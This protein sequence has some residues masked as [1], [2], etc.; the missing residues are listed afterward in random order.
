[1]KRSL[2]A[3]L[4]LGVGIGMLYVAIPSGEDLAQ[5][6]ERAETSDAKFVAPAPRVDLDN[7]I[8]L[9]SADTSI[10]FACSKSIAGKTVTV[11]GG[12]DGQL[13][14]HVLGSAAVDPSGTK[15]ARLELRIDVASL[16]SEHEQLTDSLLTKGFFCLADY[17]Q[18]TF[19]STQITKSEEE[20]NPDAAK[21]SATSLYP[22]KIEGN[23]RLNGV[24]K[25]II[26]PADIELSESQL[27]VH[28]QFSLRRADFDVHFIDTAG[29]G[30][31]SDANISDLV[32]VNVVIKTGPKPD[33]KTENTAGARAGEPEG[34]PVTEYSN[35][36]NHYTETVPATQIQFEMIL[37]PGDPDQDVD[38]YYIGKYEVTWDEFMPWV[39]GRDLHEGDSLGKLRAMKLRPSPP[40]GS[41]DRGFGMHRRP[42][43][44]MSQLSAMEYC[45]WLSE[46]T[47]KTYRLPTEQEWELAYVSGGGDAE[48][49]PTSSDAE[50][51]AVYVENSW[52]DDLDD[53]TTKP[54][55]STVSNSLGISDMA[56]NVCEWV[57]GSGKDRIA[58]GGH[59]ESDLDQ[60][61]VGRHIEGPYWNRD[62][63]N[64]PKSIWWFINARWV[65]F[66]VVAEAR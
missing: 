3:L 28:S 26:I 13:G 8:E 61:G 16:W 22:Y 25:S 43:L 20:M 23:L 57:S 50:N 49:A 12:W 14:G 44:G 30:L 45:R 63:P 47:G 33:A 6:I 11:R 37:V 46:E 5:K 4:A 7:V 41:V 58:R 60:L 27:V 19:V 38:P 18:A 21:Q 29:F 2:L 39:D 51:A 48:S 32:A 52:N 66:R 54:V 34:R 15:V 42:A 1:M 64:E 53:W 24:E 40:Y 9:S 56:G 59:F 31:L 36:P 10:G 17:P 35:L 62:Y 55:G 65:G